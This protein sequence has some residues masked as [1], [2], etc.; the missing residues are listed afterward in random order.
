ME[1]GIIIKRIF[2]M[3]VGGAVLVLCGCVGGNKIEEANGEITGVHFRYDQYSGDQFYLDANIKKIKD[4]GAK[5]E[6]TKRVGPNNYTGFKKEGK[7]KLDEN[8]VKELLDILGRYDLEAFTNYQDSGVGYS[9]TRTLIVFSGDTIL[10]D[11]AFDT[12]FPK[13]LPPE[14]DIMY[15]ELYNFFNDLVAKEPGWEEVVNDNLPDPRDNPAYGERTVTWFGNEVRLVPGTG[16]YYEDGSLA[17]IDYQG[18]DWWIEEGFIGEWVIDTE[19]TDYITDASLK[20]NEDGTVLLTVDGRQ[21]EG[22]TDDVRKY[23]GSAGVVMNIEGWEREAEVVLLKQE[24]YDEI[25]F[26]CL[27]DP[28]PGFQFDPID[29]YFN[30][31]LD[32]MSY[33]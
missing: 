2:T 13:T 6:I 26:M 9:P 4:S 19:K 10:Y 1:I 11:V 31:K 15:A 12:V 23:N 20:V 32:G 14:E 5:A 21:Y 18:K 30:K 25:R 22:K 27:P 8:E 29:V 17:D 33:E 16:T 3:I 24:S 28:V 7:I